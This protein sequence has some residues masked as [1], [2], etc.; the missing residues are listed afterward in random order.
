MEQDRAERYSEYTTP[1]NPA[2]QFIASLE[3]VALKLE[4]DRFRGRW[5]R[6]RV[7]DCEDPEVLVPINC[8]VH[9]EI[10]VRPDGEQTDTPAL[11]GGPK[12][13]RVG[14]PSSLT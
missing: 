7:L 5:E 2:R 11:I 14:K 3:A 6:R 9:E 8:V 13:N 12:C 1:G 4:V 10:T